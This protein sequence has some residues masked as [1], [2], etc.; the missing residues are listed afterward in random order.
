M[1]NERNERTII[2]CLAN[3]ECSNAVQLTKS[4]QSNEKLKCFTSR[5]VGYP[6][7]IDGGLDVKLYQHLWN[8]ID[9]QLK[10]LNIE[11]RGKDTLWEHVSQIW[12]ETALE[13]CTKL[14]ESMPERIQDVINARGSYTRW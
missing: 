8:D 1:L 7:K 14:I 13:A 2:R 12:N 6:C 10:A 11:I 5:S 4:L 3:S 9:H